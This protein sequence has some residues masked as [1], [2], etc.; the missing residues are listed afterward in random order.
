MYL[1]M[2]MILKLILKDI[3]ENFNFYDVIINNSNHF[4]HY[5]GNANKKK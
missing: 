2:I 5:K 4:T 1:F 3:F